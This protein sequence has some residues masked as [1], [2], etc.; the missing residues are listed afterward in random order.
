MLDCREQ[1]VADHLKE[2]RPKMYKELQASGNLEKVVK[3]M[4]AQYTDRLADLVSNQGVPYNQA[5]ELVRELAFPPNEKDQ[6]QLG[7]DPLR[8][9]SVETTS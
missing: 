9:T 3:G 6:P 5:Q 4:W 8:P 2:H 1:K 7:A